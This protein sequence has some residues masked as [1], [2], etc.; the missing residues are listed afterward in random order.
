MTSSPA[1]ADVSTDPTDPTDPT[2][3]PPEPD[4]GFT[5]DVGSLAPC[6]EAPP[7]VGVR[8]DVGPDDGLA[9]WV[10]ACMMPGPE[11]CPSPD[12]DVVLDVLEE[13]TSIDPYESSCGSGVIRGCGTHITD[14]V[15]CCYWSAFDGHSCPGRPFSIDGV[16]RVARL[17]AREDWCTS[18]GDEATVAVDAALAR[19]WLF[20]A[21]HEH[22]AVASFA[23]F[24]MQL[25]A[26]AAPS[27][28]VDQ[29][30]V[31]ARDEREH[32]MLFF[33]FA[34]AH[35]GVAV[36]PGPLDVRGALDDA[37]DPIAAV[38]ATV[39]EGCIA[40]TISAMQLRRACETT[41]DPDRRRALDRVLEQEL[42]HVELAWSFVAWACAHGDARMREAVAAAFE[43]A[44]RW[45]PR[46]PDDDART[47]DASR[48]RDAGRLTR[49]DA[50]AI[51]RSTIRQLV[52]PLGRE[53]LARLGPPAVATTPAVGTTLAV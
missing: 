7:N 40:E 8:C 30:L 16:A 23:R 24:S 10:T 38:V 50:D 11:G 29:A 43:G 37:E 44:D 51:A 31:A 4:V 9:Q 5:P 14:S 53:L 41:V 25:L 2:D 45:I 39:R 13:C 6:I 19:A 32:A 20:D 34:R 27:R 47:E 22:A 52:R 28:L 48:W 33:G 17:E 36:G 15:A 1:E 26:L 46:G 49:A 18:T 35:G 21:Q 12:S 42:Q 3:D